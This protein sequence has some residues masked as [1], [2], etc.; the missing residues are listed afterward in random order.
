[1]TNAIRLGFL[2]HVEGQADL[3]TLY[4]RLIAQFVAAEELGF[5]SGWIAQHHFEDG[6]SGAGAG[7]SPFRL[8]AAVAE[9][10][11]RI[12]LG[13][14]VMTIPLENPLR[15]AEDAATV[16]LISGGRVELG[17]GSGF[18]DMTFAAFGVPIAAAARV[19]LARPRP[20]STGLSTANPCSL[21]PARCCS[22]KRPACAG[23]IWQGIFSEPGA[24]YVAAAGSHLLLNRA[25]YGYD[26]R[27]DLVQRP[28]ADA[29]LDEWGKH[30]KQPRA[31]A[32][33]RR[34]P[35]H[36]SGRRQGHGQIASRGGRFAFRQT[37]GRGRQ[38]PARP[39]HSMD[40]WRGCIVST[41]TRTRSSPSSKPSR[42][43]RSQPTCYAR[44]IRAFRPSTRH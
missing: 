31:H 8:L 27:T 3:R 13:T 32:L 40:T 11:S 1:M 15:L 43:C 22:R 33:H 14:A 44:S 6:R 12:R 34:L 23:R 25:A 30:A 21:T 29:Y 10:T 5:D 39:R 26:E 4:R 2:T 7:A 37:A 41:A 17:I 35:L 9:H 36:L 24:R 38:V 42:P 28:W 16:D 18:D 19:D 20:R